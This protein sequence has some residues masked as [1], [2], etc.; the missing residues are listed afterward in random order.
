MAK[1]FHSSVYDDGLNTIKNSCTKI[2]A[3]NGVPNIADYAATLALA[4]GEVAVTAGDFTIA[5]NAGGR[6][7]SHAAT[8]GAATATTDGSEDMHLAYLDVTG[9]T[10]L[11]ITDETTDQPLTSG[12]PIV[13][14]AIELLMNAA[15]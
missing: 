3:C 6:K 9:T 4:C 2:I 7:I 8:E 15:A 14:P 11:A 12:N 13:F 10:V 5:D 1:A